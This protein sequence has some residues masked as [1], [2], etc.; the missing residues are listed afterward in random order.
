MEQFSLKWWER[1]L[2]D[3]EERIEDLKKEMKWELENNQCVPKELHKN[4]RDDI[5]LK[6]V[7][8]RKVKELKE[9]IEEI[10][11]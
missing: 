3:S 8:T 7:A 5:H 2:Q 10:N 9:L 4:L 1:E 11:I 6:R